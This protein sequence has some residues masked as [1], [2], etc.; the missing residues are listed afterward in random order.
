MHTD[1]PHR[2]AV[3]GGGIA[4][5][6]ASWELA[7]AGMK[8]DLFERDQVLGGRISNGELGGSHYDLGAES[9]ATRGGGVQRLVEDLGLAGRIQA[10]LTRRS[11]VLNAGAASPLPPAGAIGIPVS[12]LGIEARRILGFAGALRCAIEPLLPRRIGAQA[13]TIADLV[14]ARLGS[15]A[16]SRLVAPVV[17][18][19]YSTDPAA[20]PLSAVPGLESA[21][22]ARGT[23]RAAA[24][25]QRASNRSAGG[26]VAGLSGGLG[27]LVAHLENELQQFAVTVHRGAHVS[28][29][30]ETTDGIR[31]ETQAMGDAE[32]YDAVILTVP[33]EEGVAQPVQGDALTRSGSFDVA[34]DAQPAE[35]EVVALLLDDKRLN[36]APRGTGALVASEAQQGPSPIR[37]KALTHASA[38]WQW[39]DE[40]LPPN[41]HL[42]RL[43]YGEFQGRSSRNLDACTIGLDDDSVRSIARTDASRILGID[44]EESSIVGMARQRHTIPP[45]R[46]SLV[47]DGPRNEPTSGLFSAGEWVSGTGL[48]AVVPSA[49]RAA[50]DCLSHLSSPNTVT[51]KNGDQPG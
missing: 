51:A 47:T 50:N 28:A 7:R 30:R 36:S 37:A 38:K 31:L 16:L 1:S 8:V 27:V 15:K 41:H 12:P 14:G 13:S 29:A 19:V 48:A 3:V 32:T 6:V 17:R 11:W 44:I 2:V 33:L 25:A 22:R 21:W 23:L 9:F 4:G 35:V 49:R 20:L 42:I 18:G 26:A 34:R 24:R 46:T 39:L 5:L 45:R 40:E 10:P 43:S